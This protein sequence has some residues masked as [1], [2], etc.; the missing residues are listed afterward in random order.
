MFVRKLNE[1]FN[2]VTINKGRIDERTLS[3]LKWQLDKET[4]HY[5][6]NQYCIILST[7]SLDVPYDLGSEISN[8]LGTFNYTSV[9]YL[10]KNTYKLLISED[11]LKSLPLMKEPVKTDVEI[12]PEASAPISSES[13][14]KPALITVTHTDHFNVNNLSIFRS[15]PIKLQPV[16]IASEPD[17]RKVNSSI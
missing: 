11:I 2:K 5:G 6:N 16:I 9:E 15:S 4:D 3:D 8:H 7:M 1:L 10:G 13:K 17:Q 14:A 12:K